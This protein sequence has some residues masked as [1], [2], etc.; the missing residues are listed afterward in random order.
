MQYDVG[1]PGKAMQAGGTIQIGKNGAG[2]AGAPEGELRR[3]AQQGEN[4]IMAEQAGQDAAGNIS[5]PDDQ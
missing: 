2:A 1:Q 4:P 3:I 5:T